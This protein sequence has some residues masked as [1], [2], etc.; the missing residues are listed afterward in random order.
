MDLY[1]TTEL[2]AV[3]T[4]LSAIGEE[5]VNLIP[6]SGVTEAT[7]AYNVITEISREVQSNELHCNTEYDY[8]LM[9][10]SAGE[11]VVPSNALRVDAMDGSLNVVQR[12]TRLY[13][14]TNHTFMF[15]Q[16]TMKVEIVF[17]LPYEELP[18]HVRHL[19]AI[20]SARVFQRRFLGSTT[21]DGLTAQDE[22]RA[23]AAF[24]RAES[25]TDDRTYLS[26]STPSRIIRRTF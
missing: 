12:G 9:A 14:K 20:R 18:Q 24:S 25:K 26:T 5:P 11:I 3:N 19:I 21:I 4:C 17:F 7:I 22:M 13:D 8:P 16:K 6:S 23:F 15:T 2:G 10:N 1:P